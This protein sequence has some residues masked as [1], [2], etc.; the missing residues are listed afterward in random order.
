MNWG[1]CGK[2]AFSVAVCVLERVPRGVTATSAPCG[3]GCLPPPP[4][5]EGQAGAQNLTACSLSWL[6]RSTFSV[7]LWAFATST[8][9]SCQWANRSVTSRTAD[10]C[11]RHLL[12]LIL[13]QN[14]G[15]RALV[16]A[17]GQEA[18]LRLTGTR[19]AWLPVAFPALTPSPANAP[20]PGGCLP[21]L[22]PSRL[23]APTSSWRPG[24]VRPPH[25]RTRLDVGPAR[26]R[27]ERACVLQVR[28]PLGTAGRRLHRLG[29]FMDSFTRGHTSPHPRADAQNVRA[30]RGQDWKAHHVDHVTAQRQ[31]LRH[32]L[33][34]PL[35]RERGR[36]ALT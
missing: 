26:S 35:R 1:E 28:G 24:S 7:C 10:Q 36:H 29:C 33:P 25:V 6:S 14:S 3:D 5:R 31:H 22:P 4:P 20:V 23:Q 32:L 17:T 18:N 19:R 27:R 11:S 21:P 16:R 34:D 15:I 8:L 9:A 12:C 13:A 2:A 30:T